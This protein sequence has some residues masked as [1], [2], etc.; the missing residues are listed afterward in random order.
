MLKQQHQPFKP[1]AHKKSTTTNHKQQRRKQRQST[2]SLYKHQN[3]SPTNHIDDVLVVW[4][5]GLSPL[6]WPY[7]PLF[8]FSLMFNVL[9]LL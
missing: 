8:V 7:F 4:S 5:D 2:Y 6:V 9:I 1:A 3:H